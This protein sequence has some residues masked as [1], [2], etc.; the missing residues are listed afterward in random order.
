MGQRLLN[1]EV[2]S[3]ITIRPSKKI[4]INDQTLPGLMFFG[5][6]NDYPQLMEKLILGSVTAIGSSSVYA[7][8]LTG[9]GFKNPDVNKAIIGKDSKGKD[10]T[11]M[12]LLAMGAG[13]ISVNKGYYVQTNINAR[14][15]I[16]DCRLVPFKDSRFIKPDDTGYAAKIAVYDNWQKDKSKKY[17][18]DKIVTYNVFNLQKD[19]LLAQIKKAGGIK[20]YKGQIY[21]QFFDDRFFY[22]LSTF[23]ASYLDCD[24][25]AQISLYENRTLRNGFFDKII[26]STSPGGTDDEQKVFVNKVTD[27]LGPDGDNILV[28]ETDVDE[29]G[30]IDTKRAIKID[31]VETKV[32]PALFNTISESIA[33]KI[34]ITAGGI[35]KILIDY[36]GGK[37]FGLSGES[38]TVAANYFNA[39]TAKERKL[40]GDSIGEILSNFKNP[41]L[42]NNTDWEIVPLNLIKQQKDGITNT[43]T[44]T[45]D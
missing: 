40:F 22:P 20:K 8:F 1:K 38:I 30:E 11:V 12:G 28:V 44:A 19:A 25:E 23:D 31:V 14:A 43:N 29:E 18:K 6:N 27:M 45:N 32:K 17:D 36:E 41:V 13:S 37:I 35:P 4:T 3:R 7:N 5:E 15:E 9:H 10:V 34:R 2:D 33:N 21:F 39:I 42:R 26:V 16:K 24:S